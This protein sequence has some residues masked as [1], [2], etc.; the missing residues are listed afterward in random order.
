MEE[1]TAGIDHDCATTAED[2]AAD[3]EVR[4]VM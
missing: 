4:H 2:L 1:D 3:F